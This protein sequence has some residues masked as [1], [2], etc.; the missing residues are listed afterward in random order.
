[1]E[2]VVVVIVVVVAGRAIRYQ[3]SDRHLNILTEHLAEAS[4]YCPLK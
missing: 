2:V 1:M 4:D 3:E